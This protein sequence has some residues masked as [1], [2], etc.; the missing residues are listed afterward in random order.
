MNIFSL[1]YCRLTVKSEGNEVFWYVGRKDFESLKQSQ[2]LTEFGLGNLK[3]ET[4]ECKEPLIN[5]M[6]GCPAESH[7]RQLA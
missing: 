2:R 3:D 7:P 5:R 6:K 1:S 4:E